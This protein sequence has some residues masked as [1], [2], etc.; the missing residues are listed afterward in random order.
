[1]SRACSD[2]LIGTRSNMLQWSLGS[3][4]GPNPHDVRPRDGVHGHGSGRAG[5][6]VGHVAVLAVVARIRVGLYAAKEGDVAILA[7]VARQER[8]GR[9]EIGHVAGLA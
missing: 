6:E 5:T 4:L 3:P 9:A 8:R 1:M 2:R 7:V